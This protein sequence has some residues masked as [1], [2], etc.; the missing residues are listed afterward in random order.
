MLIYSM[1]IL[2]FIKDQISGYF[3]NFTK[4]YTETDK[5]SNPHE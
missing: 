4:F 2:Y 3:N 5:S 1:Y